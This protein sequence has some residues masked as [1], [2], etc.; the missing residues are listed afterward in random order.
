MQRQLGAGRAAEAWQLTP[1]LKILRGALVLSAA[2]LT[3]VVSAAPPAISRLAAA[4]TK[5]TGL[6]DLRSVSE[7]RARFNADAAFTRLVLLVSPT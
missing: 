2:T 5:S 4:Q 3:L 1:M 7:L 6:L